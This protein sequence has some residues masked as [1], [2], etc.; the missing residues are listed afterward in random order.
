MYE[1]LVTLSDSGIHLR[2]VRTEVFLSFGWISISA[3]VCS[4]EIVLGTFRH[5]KVQKFK[6]DSRLRRKII[7]F[8][9][10]I[11]RNC[12]FAHGVSSAVDNTETAA[13]S[14]MMKCARR[15]ESM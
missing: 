3:L 2:Q 12:E 14:Q 7:Y 8:I 5:A 9:M 10:D 6:R 11:H 1:L 15:Q 13:Q 4:I